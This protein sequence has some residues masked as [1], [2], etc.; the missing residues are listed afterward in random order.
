M[1][2][3]I[4]K[5]NLIVVLCTIIIALVV[6]V[7]YFLRTSRS[8]DRVDREVE[9]MFRR[10]ESGEKTKGEKLLLNYYNKKNQHDILISEDYAS[11]VLNTEKCFMVD[12]KDPECW[13]ARAVALDQLGKSEEALTALWNVA[14]YA[15]G[16]RKDQALSILASRLMASSTK[17]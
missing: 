14:E 7:G 3:T 1:E 8:N 15:T 4:S 16:T 9:E 11:V 17:E 10:I 6:G 2:I 13:F 12:P 5:K